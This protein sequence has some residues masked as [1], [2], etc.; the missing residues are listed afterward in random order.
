MQFI[1]FYSRSG[2]NIHLCVKNLESKCTEKC[3][4][5]HVPVKYAWMFNCDNWKSFNSTDNTALE[6][7]Y[8]DVNQTTLSTSQ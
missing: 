1:T 6:E 5:F 4:D 8:R 2:D 3:K 7:A